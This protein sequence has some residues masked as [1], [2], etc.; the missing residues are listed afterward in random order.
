M[1]ELNKNILVAS[2][3]RSGNALA[4]NTIW[5]NLMPKDSRFNVSFGMPAISRIGSIKEDEGI[6]KT[7]VK[8]SSCECLGLK[9]KFD[10]VYVSRDIKDVL[11]SRYF[12]ESRANR[13]S[14]DVDKD[15]FSEYVRK[16]TDSV[17]EHVRD[18]AGKD[19]I[20][21]VTFEDL[22]GDFYNIL[23]KLSE[24]LHLK[25]KRY[26]KPKLYRHWSLGPRKGIV[27]DHK[28]YFSKED[29][30]FVE[31]RLNG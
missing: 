4:M 23:G 11:V 13:Y 14:E 28:S 7:H 27:G 2:Y 12:S 8:L 19:F 9:Q 15:L 10:I 26:I 22:L 21:Y 29:Y 1:A 31:G 20:T 18:W 6:Y 17:I 16:T 30:E 25:V 5:L 24:A 3:P